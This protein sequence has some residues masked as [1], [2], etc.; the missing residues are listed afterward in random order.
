MAVVYNIKGTS[1]TEFQIGKGGPKFLKTGSDLEIQTPGGSVLIDSLSTSNLDFNGYTWPNPDDAQ[2]GQFVRFNGTELDWFSVPVP[3]TFTSISATSTGSSQDI[4]LPYGGLSVDDVNVYVNGLK[5]PVSEYSISDQT[6]TIT[7]GGSGDTIEITCPTSYVAGDGGGYFPAASAVGKILKSSSTNAGDVV[8]ADNTL[9][10]IDDVTI[11]AATNNQVLLYNGSGWVNST[12]TL[13]TNL[14]SLTDVII[15]SPTTN[16]VLQ[17]NGTNW[18]NATFNSIPSGGTTNQVLAKTS[19]TDY[20]VAWTSYLPISITTASG[21]SYTLVNGD[22]Y[23]R[24]TNT[25]AL[26]VT[27]PTNA[28][29]AFPVGTQLT[30]VRTNAAVTIQAVDGTVTILNSDG[31]ALRKAGSAATLTKVGTNSWDFAGDVVIN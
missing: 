21:T 23:V 15:S 31:M 24:C 12:L 29:A 2:G 3:A 16:Q 30:I 26:I 17:Y 28:T 14:D 9:N 6:L 5:F 7:T 18:I 11:T 4:P 1:Q 10:G 20:A 25:A 13:S 27:V 22:T 19:G 8:W